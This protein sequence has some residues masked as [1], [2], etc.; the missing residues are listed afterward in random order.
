MVLASLLILH[1]FV[2]TV[3]FAGEEEPRGEAGFWRTFFDFTV[4]GYAIAL[5]VNLYMLWTF[6]R[7]AGMPFSE[8]IMVIVVLG[9]PAALGAAIARLV[10]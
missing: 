9:F 1:A 4:V 3:G 5:L 6:E 7:T 10:V 2:Y 8:E